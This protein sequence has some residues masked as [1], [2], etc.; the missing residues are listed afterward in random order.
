MFSHGLFPFLRE[1][2]RDT[3]CNN[4]IKRFL[5]PHSVV[6]F[7]TNYAARSND[8]TPAASILD[9]SCIEPL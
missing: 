2:Q 6:F 8:F 7:L 5:L 1:I 4:Y 3:T 9:P